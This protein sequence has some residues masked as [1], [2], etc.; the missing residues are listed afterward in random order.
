MGVGAGA[1]GGVI[2]L[3]GSGVSA[4]G[5]MQK[6]NIEAKN[7]ENQGVMQGMQAMWQ[8]GQLNIDAAMQDLNATQTDLYLRQKNYEQMGQINAVVAMTG[9]D[10]DSPSN[11][12]VKNRFET[13][14]DNQRENADWN[15]HMQA[16]QDRN[17]AQIALLSGM[18]NM[19]LAQENAGAIRSGGRMS[20][21]GGMLGGLGGLFG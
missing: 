13:L 5:Q 19:S 11:N 16:E 21:I 17:M 6:A 2:G 4:M 10:Y 3:A 15:Y 7:A 18:I 9:S 1:I 20:A 14:N 8:A 12:A